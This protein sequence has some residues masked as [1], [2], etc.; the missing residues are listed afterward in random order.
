MD[1]LVGRASNTEQCP[2]YGDGMLR[3]GEFTAYQYTGKCGDFD[4]DAFLGES[5]DGFDS[6]EL[7]GGKVVGDSMEAR[8]YLK[9]GVLQIPQF[10]QELDSVPLAGFAVYKFDLG[11]TFDPTNFDISIRYAPFTLGL[12]ASFGR[13]GSGM[14]MHFSPAAETMGWNTLQ[15]YEAQYT[16]TG[17]SLDL[18]AKTLSTKDLQTGDMES[19]TLATTMF[20]TT[21]TLYVKGNEVDSSDESPEAMPKVETR[22]SGRSDKDSLVPAPPTTAA[23]SSASSTRSA[24]S[25][26]RRRASARRSARV[27]NLN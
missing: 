10:P 8:D 5:Q 19:F 3:D 20:P 12:P 2:D 14:S 26:A 13:V 9:A 11:L 6:F 16:P 4:G 15:E 18:T 21:R 17:I 1:M 23:V 27:M 24:W 25:R 22:P 7:M